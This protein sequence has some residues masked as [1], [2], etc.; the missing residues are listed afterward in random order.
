MSLAVGTRVGSY[1]ILSLIGAGGMGEVYRAKDTRLK[2]DVAIKVLPE[3]FANDPERVARLQREAELLASLSHPNIAQIHGIEQNALVLELIDG[4][5]LADRIAQGP[6][7]LDEA[8]PIARQIAEALEA[9]HEQGIIHRDLKPANIKLRPDGAVKVLDFGLAKALEPVSVQGGDVT[10]SP[11]ITSPAMTKM[12]IILGTAAYM[13]PEQARGK[14]VDKRTDIWA[15]GCVLYEM[16]TG[17]RAFDGDEVTDVLASVLERD[18]DLRAVPVSVP[19]AVRRLLRRC[20]AKDRR[21]RLSGIEVARLEIDEALIGAPEIAQAPSAAALSRWEHVAWAAAVVG[22]AAIVGN[23]AYHSRPS[24]PPPAEVRFEIPVTQMRFI[25]DFSVSPDGRRVAFAAAAPDGR[26]GVWIRALDSP[27]ARLLPGTENSAPQSVWPAWSPDSRFIVFA[28]DGNLKKIDVTGG[29]P[30]TLTP[31]GGQ[32]GGA[33]WNRDNVIIFGSN[34]HGLRRISASGGEVTAVSERDKSLEETY[35]DAPVFLP[36]GKHFLYL[37]WSNPKPENRAIFISSLDSPSRTRLMTAESNAVYAQGHLLFLRGDTLVGQPFDPDRLQFT[38]DAVALDVRVAKVTGEVAAVSVSDTGT[39]VYRAPGDETPSR[40]LL[41]MDRTG[42][43]VRA[44]D[45]D[46]QMTPGLKL[47]T[48]G[49]QIAFTEGLPPDIFI[50]DFDRRTKTRLTTHPSVDHSPVWSPDGTRVVF[51]SHRTLD[52]QATS[53]AGLYEK[54][55]NGATVEQP[56]LDRENGVQH[57]PRDWSADGSTLVFAKQGQNGR[58]NLWGLPL[59]GDRK[60]FPYRS[61]EFNE[62]EASLSPNGR[63]LAFTSN[64][65]GKNEVIVQPFPDPSRGRW[66]ISTEGGSAPRWRR[67][68]RELFYLDLKGRLTGVSVTTTPDFSIQKPTLQIQTPLPVP[69]PVGGV[70]FP[71]D[72]AP[73]GERFLLTVPIKG[74]AATPISVRVNWAFLAGSRR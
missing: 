26:E 63:F 65:S 50:Y 32:M 39:L 34:D 20:L 23:A 62:N 33:T 59:T 8:L 48:S 24:P 45:V 30:Q 67:D 47:S 56:I 10:A 68:G 25:S 69:L 6:I 60:P 37:A 27:T 58:W 66:Q 61:G 1:E 57:S 73:D 42:K 11:T 28:A 7:P 2:R 43:T 22:A 41:W 49:K 40:Q 9:A 36:D 31:L 13:S 21:E 5:T 3:A 29:P 70:L 53:E 14:A 52:G 4:P 38:G 19:P 54:P 16:L 44:T 12:G 51:D 35:H 15:F 17:R 18:V 46:F 55:S 74:V 72:V 64:E 71:Y